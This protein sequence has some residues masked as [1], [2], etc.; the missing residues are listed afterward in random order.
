L[1]PVD[2]P[3]RRLGRLITES[4][5]HA[6][7]TI[8]DL[9][10]ANYR[11][12]ASYTEL[13][14][15]EAGRRPID[16]GMLE[17]LVELYGIDPIEM[18]PER[19]ELVIDLDEKMLIADVAS[20]TLEHADDGHHVL[21]RYLGLVYSLRDMDPGTSI[22]LRDVDLEVLAGAISRPAD[23][24]ERSLHM[25]MAPSNPE[26]AAQVTKLRSRRLIA[27][28]GIV[29]GAT[30]VGTVVAVGSQTQREGGSSADQR[31]VP[32]EVS[33]D[34]SG[35]AIIPAMVAE[36]SSPDAEAVVSER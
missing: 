3:T 6:G 28:A 30:V 22:P 2:V 8:E 7:V 20:T 34:P 17:R 16:A 31:L 35:A 1:T 25:M 15:V 32:A 36:R 11:G 33:V 29:L 21:T 13:T 10:K 26:V 27:F 19:T 5:E 14:D 24:I 12:L 23:D 18:V 9:V 4:R